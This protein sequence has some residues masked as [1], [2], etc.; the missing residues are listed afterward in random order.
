[1][2]GKEP[3]TG[4]I[5]PFCDKIGGEVLLENVLIFERIM[6]LGIGHGAAIKPHIDKVEFAGHCLAR[7]TH[8]GN[9]IHVRAVQILGEIF[10]RLLQS[11]DLVGFF[12]FFVEFIDAADADFFAAVFCAPNGQGCSPEARAGKV[13]IHEV[14]QPVT[15]SAFTG[16]SG[17]PVD[18]FIELHQAIFHGCCA[19]EPTFQGVIEDGFIGTPAVGVGMLVFFD[20]KGFV[21]LF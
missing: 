20:L 5:H 19:H 18:G 13:P 10:C 3:T 8:Q 2:E 6:P 11:K 12:D 15:E 17:F 21:F 7:S 9:S 16:R 4:L 14:F 1:M